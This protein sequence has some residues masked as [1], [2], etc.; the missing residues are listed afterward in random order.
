M[1]CLPIISPSIIRDSMSFLL[2]AK[3]SKISLDDK[4]SIYRDFIF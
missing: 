3:K 4:Q 1:A 2:K